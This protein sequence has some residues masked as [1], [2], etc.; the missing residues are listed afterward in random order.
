MVLDGSVADA[1]ITVP[2][3]NVTPL[4]QRLLATTR[5]ALFERG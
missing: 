1:A 5:A 2:V 4:A 3:G